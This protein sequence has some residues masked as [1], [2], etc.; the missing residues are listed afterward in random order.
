M[1]QA[2]VRAIRV[3]HT[4]YVPDQIV[5]MGGVGIA[6]KPNASALDREIRDGLTSLARP[7]WELH[8]GDYAYHAAVG[9][10][11]FAGSSFD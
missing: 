2:L 11:R 3:V 4:I 1:I 10:A 7:G 6:L 9:A 5:L 8:F